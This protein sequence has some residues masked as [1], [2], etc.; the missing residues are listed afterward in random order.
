MI[1]FNK[2]PSIPFRKG[3]LRR[4]QCLTWLV[5]RTKER[6]RSNVPN[7]KKQCSCRLSGSSE[8][9]AFEGCRSTDLVLKN[10]L[11]NVLCLFSV[12]LPI[13]RSRLT[14]NQFYREEPLWKITIS[15]N[16]VV[17]E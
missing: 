12:K 3:D 5:E 16:Q 6:Q 14:V 9:R 11:R 15:Q 13:E 2:S 7:P 10:W 4:L 8:N 17:C 1:V